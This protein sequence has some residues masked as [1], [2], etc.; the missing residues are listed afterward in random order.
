MKE[1]ITE[2]EINGTIDR[3]WEVLTNFSSFPEWNPFI[4]QI[5]GD[6]NIGAQLK[7]LI[8]PPGGKAMTFKPIVKILEPEN[9]FRWLGSLLFPGIFDGE[10]IF[11]LEQINDN[12]TKFIH[13]ETFTG[14]LVPLFWKSLNSNTRI[15][16]EE[17]NKALKERIEAIQIFTDH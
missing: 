17:M 12:K 3:V 14:L 2:I 10:H 16:F 13:R 7:V 6:L 1:L 8:E 5:E 11:R 9:E 15:G 4:K